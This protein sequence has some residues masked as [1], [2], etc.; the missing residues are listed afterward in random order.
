MRRRR[1]I[2]LLIIIGVIFLIS[3]PSIDIEEN[4]GIILENEKMFSFTD[5]TEELGVAYVQNKKEMI[6]V[7]RS[8][9]TLPEL[10]SGAVAVADYD[11][12]GYT[13]IFVTRL[14]DTDILYRNNGGTFE[15]VSSSVGLTLNLPSNGAGFFDIEN[16][17]DLDLFVT[18]IG[19]RYYLFVNNDGIFSEEALERIPDDSIHNGFSVS[20]GD[21]DNDGYTDIHTT[22]WNGKYSKEGDNYGR[23]FRNLGNGKF[24]DKSELLNIENST[25]N[26][27]SFASSFVDINNDGYQD[28]AIVADFGNSKLLLNTNGKFSDITESA[29]LGEDTFGMGNAIGDLDND[30]NLD[31]FISS[32][33]YCKEDDCLDKFGGN[34]LYLNKGDENYIDSTEKF[35]VTNGDWGWASSFLDID[36]DGDLDLIQVSGMSEFIMG[37]RRNFSNT[38][39]KLWINEDGV[40]FEKA[41]DLGLTDLGDMRGLSVL[42][43]DNDGDLDLFITRNS[44]SGI[45][46]RNN[47]DY[48][49]WF[50][51]KL[52]SNKNVF[53]TRATIKTDSGMYSSVLIGGNNFLGMNEQIIHFGLG[54]N[55]IIEELTIEWASGKKTIMENIGV[56]QLLVVEE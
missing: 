16:D 32:I 6:D 38:G 33:Y 7:E 27:V 13:D 14:D 35:N 54:K 56:N 25:Y 49:N 22:D 53:G 26:R 3:Y 39:I 37:S 34:K 47:L 17:G 43:F 52:I 51:I 18:T 45:L 36:N 5:V 21:Y 12:D 24:E 48:N 28:L 42:D 11:N 20:F 4:D 23:L 1:I 31:W 15:D 44:D 40:L 2:F 41:K 10:F 55:K 19:D 8:N 29:R 46:Y 9:L 50:R 30:G